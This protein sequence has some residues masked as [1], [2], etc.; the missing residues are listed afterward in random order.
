MTSGEIIST[1]ALNQGTAFQNVKVPK[2]RFFE[3]DATTASKRR[4]I[5]DEV[6]EITLLAI[7]NA[8][9]TNIPSV[10]NDEVVYEEIYFFHI[11]LNKDTHLAELHQFLQQQ[12]KNPAIFIFTLGED[13][14][15]GAALKRL[16]KSVADTT[17]VDTHIL[18][19]WLR[20]TDSKVCAYLKEGQITK[21]SFLNLERTYL[22]MV[23]YIKHAALLPFGNAVV[24][25][26]RRDWT[27]I[28]QYLS[29]YRAKTSEYNRLRDEEKSHTAFGEK[30]SLR[31]K[32]VT[33]EKKLTE[34]TDILTKLLENRP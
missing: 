26:R 5:A 13:I 1:F 14:A 31:S 33:I 11:V 34:I 7:Y 32:Q 21:G 15:L 6:N 25:D 27:Q 2:I 18:S 12:I 23:S 9:T 24:I 10:R 30:L 19:P 28:D 4:L 17:V 20:T 22:D 8:D 16:N 3:L 29:D